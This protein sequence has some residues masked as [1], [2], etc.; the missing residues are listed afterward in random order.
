MKNN[1]LKWV[2]MEVSKTGKYFLR[3]FGRCFL[4]SCSFFI[5]FPMA[6]QSSL[7]DY[8]KLAAENNPALKSSYSSFEASMKR[9]PQ[10]SALPEPKL[11]F[12]YFI[13]PI[14]TRVG[15]QRSRVSL[16]QAFPWFGTL[17]AK[18]QVATLEAE[19]NYQEFLDQKNFLF[20]QVKQAYYPLY[21]VKEHLHLQK[22]N[23][24]ILQT[25]RQLAETRFS[26]GQGKMTDVLRVELLM[27]DARTDILLLEQRVAPLEAHFNRMLDRE[28]SIQVL[29][30]DTLTI[31]DEK[32][33]LSKADTLKPHPKIKILEK[34]LATHRAQEE[35]VRKSGMP[36][37]GVGLDY[38]FVSERMEANLPDNGR[39]AFMPTVTLSIPIYRK[40]YSAALQESRSLQQSAAHQ[41]KAMENILVSDYETA[42]YELEKAVLLNSRYW[43]QIQKTE[44]ILTLL[45]TTYSNLGENFEEILKMQQQLLSYRTASATDITAY[46]LALA[47]I[48]YI[49]T[50]SE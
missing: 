39:D 28:D 43:R 44:R 2:A 24:R 21:E 25:F 50:K 30:P 38:A 1:T 40:K 34:R 45:Y 3:T 47:R 17:K 33:I 6:A 18:K 41:V 37:I 26:N 11:S 23:L 42:R 16:S 31:T 12:G 19:A 27:E 36:Q 15:A 46:H 14:E 5:T 22:E 29:I 32:P 35:V 20:Y 10:V 4:L 8:L 49:T 9:I 13:S 7:E 48:A